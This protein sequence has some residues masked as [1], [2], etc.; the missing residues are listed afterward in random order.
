M[1]RLAEG[2]LHEFQ[3]LHEG[4]ATKSVRLFQWALQRALALI[5]FAWLDL[6]TAVI[7]FC[8]PE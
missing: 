7:T 5:D 8:Y 3:L 6:D 4:V 1:Q 2:P